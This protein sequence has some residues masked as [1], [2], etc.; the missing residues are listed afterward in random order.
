MDKQDFAFKSR[1]PGILSDYFTDDLVP[2]LPDLNQFT[3]RI[4]TIAIQHI[5]NN[6]ADMLKLGFGSFCL[7]LCERS[8]NSC[9]DKF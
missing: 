3:I 5:R 8:T 7:G 1:R 9:Y 4:S 6:V 2:H